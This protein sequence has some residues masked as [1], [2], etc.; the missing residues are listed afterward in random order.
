MPADVGSIPGSG[1]FTGEGND[2][3]RTLQEYSNILASEI[4]RTEEP[5]GLQS[6]GS[7]I[8]G[9]ELSACPHT[10]THTHTPTHT[11]DIRQPS[12]NAE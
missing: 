2:N 12:V 8:V 6:M 10:H 5:G 1:R 11:R 9:H 4:P 7:Q 3:S